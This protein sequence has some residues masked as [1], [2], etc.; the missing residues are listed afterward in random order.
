MAKFVVTDELAADRML[1][2]RIAAD[3]WPVP[4]IP[5]LIYRGRVIQ[6]FLAA[7]AGSRGL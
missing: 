3:P 4:T 5:G 6:H 2:E 1:V 7:A